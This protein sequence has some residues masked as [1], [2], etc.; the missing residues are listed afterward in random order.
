VAYEIGTF[1]QD[2]GFDS[3]DWD[4]LKGGG[5]TVMGVLVD[6][7]QTMQNDNPDLNI[8][9]IFTDGYIAMNDIQ[10]EKFN[11]KI[12]V[13]IPEGGAELQLENIDVIH[14]W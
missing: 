7:A 2:D 9:I 14:T 12:I 1:T 4:R 8:C 13:I 3:I 6:K 10:A 11:G 5:G